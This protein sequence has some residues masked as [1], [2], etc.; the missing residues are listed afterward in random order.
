MSGTATTAAS[1]WQ[2][3]AREK[4]GGASGSCSSRPAART[5]PVAGLE[6]QFRIPRN[7]GATDGPRGGDGGRGD[8]EQ[9]A[10]QGSPDACPA[11]CSLGWCAQAWT[12]RVVLLSVLIGALAALSY[13]T[14]QVDVASCAMSYSRPQYL[15]QTE[16][17][18]SWTRYSTKYKL[19]LYRE[20]GFDRHMNPSRVPV[21][22]IPG[23]AGSHKQ[24]RSIASATSSAFVDFVGKNPDAAAERGQIGYDFF[25]MSL[26]EELTALHGY[27]ILEQADF[28]N[29]AIRY[30]LSLYPKSRARHAQAA[31]GATL[32]L[33]TSVAIIGHS[34]GGVVARTAFTLP[35]YIAGSVQAIFTLSTPHNNP[36]A[37]LECHVSDVYDRVNRFWRHG[38]R[39]GT[40]GDVSLVSL[41]G[42]SLDAMI[43]SDY[44]YVGDIAPPRNALSVLSSGVNDVWLSV[45]HQSVLWCYQMARKFAAMIVQVLDA[46]RPSQL[47]PLDERM[48]IM[49]RQLYS[50]I[51]DGFAAS[52]PQIARTTATESYRY[53]HLAASTTLTLSPTDVAALLSA[54]DVRPRKARAM[55]LLP[56]DGQAAGARPVLQLLYDPR[57]FTA[58]H[59]EVELAQFQPALL[60]CN[61]RA[62]Q[63]TPDA[64]PGVICETVPMPEVAKLPLRRRSDDR[65]APVNSLHYLEA[66]LAVVERFEYLGLEIP[67]D[68]TAEGFLQAAVVDAPKQLEWSPGHRRLALPTTIRVPASGDALGMRTRIR[69]AVPENPLI[70]FRATITAQHSAPEAESQP[71]RFHPVVR[72]SD[73]RRFESK[74]WYDERV[75]DIAIHGRGVYFSDESLAGAGEDGRAAGAQWD[76]LYI[77]IWA[78]TAAVSGLDVT[79]RINWYSSLNRMVK[80]YD[81]ALLA[82][83]FV[84][85]CLVMAH[86][87][88]TWNAGAA[89]ESAADAGEPPVFPSCLSSIERLIRNGTL[90]AM[91]VAGLLTPVA[92]ELVAWTMRDTWSPEVMLWWNNLFMG[93]RG[94]G[95]TLCLA[96]VLLVVISLGFV[97]LQALVLAAICKLV[98]RM[99]VRSSR[100]ASSADVAAASAECPKQQPADLLARALLA[101]LAFVVLVSTLVPYQFAF[102]VIYMAQLIT[103]VQTVSS[104]YL[105]AASGTRQR[106][107]AAAALQ[108]L[109]NYQ[110]G[111]LLFWTSGLPYCAPELL[112][113]V[114]N[115]SVLWFEDAPADHNLANVAGY[116]ALR[117]LAS[118]RVVPRLSGRTAWLPRM[119]VYTV[120]GLSIA[121]AWLFGTRKPYVLY[122]VANAISALLVA[123]HVLDGP[124]RRIAAAGKR[125]PTPPSPDTASP[126]ELPPASLSANNRSAQ[127]TARLASGTPKSQLDRKLR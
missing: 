2:A 20:G 55:H 99:V 59:D 40:L 117:L 121:Y 64:A 98:A 73:G 94:S 37:S 79:L 67:A 44:A 11:A 62:S 101:T 28:V 86:Q 15:E 123:V 29:D 78:D 54:S 87:L 50:S 109:A 31:G 36:T 125:T 18:Q 77:D 127:E 61:R 51:D 1:E 88:W 126:T 72:Q 102:L 81:M 106:M 115:L 110:L 38:F 66:P 97:V 49:R 116:F 9:P 26:N 33:P 69:L 34:M 21:L 112:V 24:V 100:A 113:W 19:F 82:L 8:S 63:G 111:L 57:L 4:S 41:A 23:N 10:R 22:F 108:S 7:G 76:G 12:L 91:L 46:R 103:V 65:S 105:A 84:W 95:W 56:L 118:Y 96:P 114:R 52:R 16:F 48:D 70:V 27:S 39:N 90:A 124:L 43:N 60:G 30:I 85:A 80:R 14:G 35:S 53:V 47:L 122:T 119:L 107:H 104:A 71:P 13:F 17:G 74:F 6:G 120:I 25:T 89:A 45:D 5:P 58:H 42:G 75:A 93:V 83:S 3:R 68:A 32:A 92:Q